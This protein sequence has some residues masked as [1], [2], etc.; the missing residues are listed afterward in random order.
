[1][2]VYYA[3]YGSAIIIEIQK[4]WIANHKFYICVKWF[5]KQKTKCDKCESSSSVPQ[6]FDP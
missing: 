4:I 1:M 6:I 3:N 5:W 2:I